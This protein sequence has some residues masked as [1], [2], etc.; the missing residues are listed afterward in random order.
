[1]ADAEKSPRDKKTSILFFILLLYAG[2]FII[3]YGLTYAFYALLAGPNIFAPAASCTVTGAGAK[4]ASVCQ[5]LVAL[6]AK[7]VSPWFYGGLIVTI[8]VLVAWRFRSKKTA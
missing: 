3:Y 6:Q 2:C 5:T 7:F 8:G 4:A 1:M